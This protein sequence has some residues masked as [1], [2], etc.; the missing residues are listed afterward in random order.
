MSTAVTLNGA[1]KKYGAVDA[2]AGLTLEVQ[3][4]EMFG[5]IGADGAGKTTAIRV[6]CGLLKLTEGEVRV[7]GYQ[8]VREHR[9]LTSRVGY[10]SQRFSLYGDLTIDENRSRQL[11]RPPR[12]AVAHLRQRSHRCADPGRP[13]GG[14]RGSRRRGSDTR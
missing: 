4:G 14:R 13:G 8:P 9:Q 1:V 6:M 12:P 7:L 11:P 10:L 3:R 5:L 2:L